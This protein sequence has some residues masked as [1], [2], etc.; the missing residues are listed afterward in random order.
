MSWV[1]ISLIVFGLIFALV[2]SSLWI[3]IALAIAGSIGG[4]LFTNFEVGSAV[5]MTAFA[6]SNSFILTALP[7]FVFMG[8]LLFV[9]RISDRLY[10][11]IS[12]WVSR[13]PGGL[14]HSNIL[15]CTLF[16][17]ISGSSAVTTAT[18]GT[19]AIPELGKRGYDKGMVL[20]SL[21]GAGTLG[22]LIPPS[23]VMIVY[24]AMTGNSVGQL[25]IAGV[26]PGLLI[27]ALFMTFIGVVASRNREIAP[28]RGT[29]SWRDRMASIVLVLPTFFVIGMVLGLIY[30]G[31]TT[32]TEAGAIGALCAFLL[33]LHYRC[34]TWKALKD[35]M[36]ET[37]RIS[38]MIMLIVMGASILSTMVAYLKI[39]Q[40]LA[41]FV[42]S[43]GL[44][45][46]VILGIICIIYLG[47]GCLFDGISM[48][49]LTLPI[50][51]PLVLEMGFDGLWFGVMVV[52]LIEVAQITPP[53]GF[54]LY[55][56]KNMS[57]WPIEKIVRSTIPF[58]ILMLLG[59]IVV[60]IFPDIATW[61]PSI[62]IRR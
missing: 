25:F 19:V 54:N 23:I 33:T 9:S 36:K 17:S 27:A 39:P 12:P 31:I 35:S 13:L 34:F 51:Y 41:R 3:G 57:G 49:V 11:G 50:L 4:L 14:L 26:I 5:V 6:S 56:L 53:V 43:L 44:S 2:G 29:P 22:L 7:F 24:G 21:A 30:L 48:M 8:E 10:A 16:A 52:I 40:E 61:L 1:S 55:V 47:L 59:V 18:I 58:F 20:G 38:C 46:Y 42:A 32:P 60:T 28:T 15:A 45:R 62:M 37:I